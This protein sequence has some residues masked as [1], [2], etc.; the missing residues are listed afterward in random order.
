MSISPPT[1][2]LRVGSLGN[3]AIRLD[4]QGFGDI[5]GVQLSLRFDPA[6]LE[7][8]SVDPVGTTFPSSVGPVID[9]TAGTVLFAAFTL[10]PLPA[11]HQPI[12]I[13]TIDFRAKA[14]GASEV[15]FEYAANG[16]KTVVA[17]RQGGNLLEDKKDFVGA[18]IVVHP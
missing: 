14:R 18:Q 9:N 6:V 2:N 3:F 10:S 5:T 12:D 4:P 16:S 1:R 17:D 13:A 8:V 7:V 15:I 11:G